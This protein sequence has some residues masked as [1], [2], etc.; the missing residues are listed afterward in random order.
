MAA[1][2]FISCIMPTYGRP[3]YVN[4]S[5]AMFLAQDYPYKELVILN[6][7][8]G[9]HF[10]SDIPNVRVINHDAR[11][12][13][14]G[15]KRNRC[16]ELAQGSVIA[17]WDDDDVYLPWRMSFSWSE[18]DRL[19]TPF[20]RP[21]EFLAYWGDENLHDNHAVPGWLSHAWVMFSKALW[22]KVGGY[23]DANLGEDALFFERIH[24]AL[25]EDFIKYALAREDRFGILRG[26][27]HYHHMS[28][29]GGKHPLD[30]GPGT[31]PIIPSII[32][33]PILR[34]VHD[35]LVASRPS[36]RGLSGRDG[37]TG[38]AV[39]LETERAG[40]DANP[41]LSVCVSLKNRSRI[42]HGAGELDLFPR[43]VTALAAAQQDAGI[44]IE[45]VVA[46]FASDDWPPAEW[47]AS[48]AAATPVRVVSVDGGFSRGRGLNVAVAHARS[49]ALLL[50]DADVLVSSAALRRAVDVIG[51][52]QAWFP[53]W[54]CLDEHGAPAEWQDL[55]HGVAGVSRKLFDAAGG[56]PE[57]RS[58]GGEDD[59]FASRVRALAGIVR[60]R[61]DG[62]D[63]QWH[64]EWCRHAHYERPRQADYHHYL[65]AQ[66]L[67]ASMS[68]GKL[69]KA[70][71]A[72]HPH[73]VGSQLVLLLNNGRMERVGVEIGT[74]EFEE[75]KRLALQWDH[76]PEE[77]LVWDGRQSV[78]RDLTKAFTLT[79]IGP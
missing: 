36:K 42:R 41:V 40:T 74:Y 79:P 47:I 24:D 3:Q 18:M 34:A 26:T 17:I 33:D 32:G 62:V 30:I 1:P 22:E 39:V 65:D 21:A 50:C 20:Y 59:I 73:W 9:Q 8:P 38:D 64:P 78:F 14:L 28:I 45:L 49:D 76:W 5:V 52:Q 55:G 10:A 67:R 23:P 57:F 66:A 58:W 19:G 46:D 61:F 71:R 12:A 56:V 29:D 63:H 77:V 54:R 25:G 53:I 51:S 4:E 2:P 75:Q 27:S 43:C 48:A 35:R 72:S 6:D 60:E 15:E 68:S 13:S 7:C 69:F 70:F 11:F 37:G 44:E 31:Y 16:I